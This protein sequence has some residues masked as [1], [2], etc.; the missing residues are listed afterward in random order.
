MLKNRWMLQFAWLLLCVFFIGFPA[1]AE[2]NQVD[3]LFIIDSWNTEKGLPQSSVISVIQTRDGYLWLGTL[4]GLVRFDGNKF[5]VFDENNTPGLNSDR[6][7]FLFEDSRTNL[8]IG[9]DAGGVAL[10]K[11]GKI[12]N[13]EIGSSGY[14][15][16]LL[17]VFEDSKGIVWFYTADGR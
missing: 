6:I 8:W 5:T 4:N 14:A 10:L 11:D 12:E 15:G 16:R 7:V 2:T 3:S 1:V 17:Y 13:F 9:T